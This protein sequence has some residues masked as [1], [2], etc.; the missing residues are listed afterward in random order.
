MKA[1][2]Y[3]QLLAIVLVLTLLVQL[4]PLQTL[5]ATTSMDEE[6]TSLTN[7]LV[8]SEAPPI[9]VICE[10]E[11]LRTETEKHFRMSDG[12]FMAVSYGIPV[13]Y[14]DDDGTW[15]DI[16]N[17]LSQTSNQSAYCVNNDQVATT[18][19]SNLNSGEVFT[20]SYNGTS[21]SIS[22]LDATQSTSM[23]AASQSM[24]ATIQEGQNALTV[25]DR[26]VVA[27]ATVATE[28]VLN[29]TVPGKGWTATDVIPETLQSSVL[30]EDVYP[31]VD[32]LYTA[33]GYNI[34]EQIIVNE[35][36][37][38]YRYDFEL[39]LDGLEAVLNEDGSV[40]LVNADNERIYYIPAPF[41]EDA[42]GEMSYEVSY[43]L[44][45]IAGGIILSVEA[46]AEWL[47]DEDRAFPVAIDPT[48]EVQAGSDQ[49]D[50]YTSHTVQ[51][52]PDTSYGG[53]QYF[54]L[55]YS[56]W[57]NTQEYRGFVHFNN[58][59]TIPSGAVITEALFGLYMH[60][61]SYVNL[62]E[63]G[64]GAYEVTGEKPE[65]IGS[66]YD[67]IYNLTWNTMPTYD[68]S[69]LIDYTVVSNEAQNQYYY[70]DLSELV[71]KWYTEETENR[72]IAM[73]MNEGSYSDTNYAQ[74]VFYSW[75][76]NSPPMLFVSYRSVLG[77]EDYYTYATL[78]AGAAGSAYISDYTGQLTITKELVS[79]ASTINPFAMN[80]VYNSN[81]NANNDLDSDYPS[82]E[83]IDARIGVGWTLDVLQTV[84]IDIINNTAHIR[85]RDG[86]GTVHY[87]QKDPD[88]PSDKQYFDEDGLGLE[89]NI[90]RGQMAYILSDSQ[91]NTYTFRSG[92]L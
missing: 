38:A 15:H 78:G 37:S 6:I 87:L 2:W 44:T 10:E 34:K 32:L 9:T 60:D 73:T 24:T 12:S 20:T 74:P 19:A 27:D 13:H 21:V 35:P 69:N 84:K 30:Y 90:D 63:L 53:Y 82:E 64:I 48:I 8:E 80:L 56:E 92:K 33:Y 57:L 66:Y 55:G 68:T 36:Q 88:N 47:N 72:T 67:W 29:P 46:D 3:Q 65:T 5:A 59:P 76:N 62:T 52:K 42:N 41:M 86:D 31:N 91:D 4:L 26:N 83:F 49:D 77:I 14:M 61:Y 58:I 51:G 23:A 39:E 75:A 54:H 18:F 81:Y 43:A 7:S 22:L 79:Y 16:D 50:I 17:T 11:T 89:L 70:W 40:S 25:Y 45:N 71:K 28:S 85:Y 1:H